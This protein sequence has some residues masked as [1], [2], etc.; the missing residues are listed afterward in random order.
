[1]AMPL[2][3]DTRVLQCF[4]FSPVWGGGE[5]LICHRFDPLLYVMF[6]FKQR[7]HGHDH[8]GSGMCNN[9]RSAVKGLL[10]C[11]QNTEAVAMC[12]VPWNTP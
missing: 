12:C 3:M 9:T 1:M 4:F 11:R 10:L 7:G 2:K 5:V 6:M 8:L